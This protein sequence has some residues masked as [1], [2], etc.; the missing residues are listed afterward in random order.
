MGLTFSTMKRYTNAYMCMTLPLS[1][2]AIYLAALTV[3]LMFLGPLRRAA[4]CQVLLRS[5][6]LALTNSNPVGGSCHQLLPEPLAT[7]LHVSASAS[8][9]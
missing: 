5:M 7:D 8:G 4:A 2:L 1:Q 9:S 6:A 3:I